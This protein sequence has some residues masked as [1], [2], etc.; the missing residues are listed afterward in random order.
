M[1]FPKPARPIDSEVAATSA[2]LAAVLTIGLMTVG[3]YGITSDEFLFDAYGPKALAWYLSGFTDRTWFDY[4]DERPYGPWFQ[5]LVTAVQSLGLA[6]R[7]TV[8]HAVTFVIGI[9]GLAALL[10]LARL[11]VGRWA[12]FSAIVL[13]LITG[14]LYGHLFFTPYD[15]P[16][17]ATMTWATLA[18][19]VMARDPV[20][21]W[22]VV[23]AVGLLT[24]LAIATRPGGVLVQIYLLAAMALCGLEA[25]LA[26]R[27][28]VVLRR[29]GMRTAVAILA[30]WPVAIALWPF[31]QVQ[32][33]A[34]GFAIAFAH[35]ANIG[36]DFGIW[37]WGQRLSSAALPWRY[38]PG[39][40]L[41]RLPT[42]F[43][44]LLAVAAVCG[45]ANAFRLAVACANDM[46]R[47]GRAGMLG[48]LA[49]LAHNRAMLVLATAAVA[50]L[51]FV[52]VMRPIIF[53]GI[54]HL[55]FTIPLLALLATWGL[56]RL[57]PLVRR[58]PYVWSTLAGAYVAAAVGTMALLHPLEYVATNA[59]AGGV[60]RSVGRFDLDYW[61]GAATEAL[62]RLEQR[63]AY[64]DSQRVASSPPRIHICI[65]WREQL[66]APMFRRPWKL[67]FD[68]QKAEYVIETERSHCA[69]R[70][71]AVLIDEVKRFDRAF[72]WTYQNRAAGG[73]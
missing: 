63:V 21:S 16:F 60:A 67:E 56:L 15:V 64:D 22:G 70:A 6:E 46:Q 28:R 32:N 14:N 8:R 17:L 36:L 50:P 66:V 35:F 7:F 30:A 42:V 65:P 23:A 2:L 73:R 29:M 58:L 31:L 48:A 51:A 62:R 13:C 25:F 19:V 61:L 59:L 26:R 18:V 43:I 38:V 27:D 57:L 41:A 34:V 1:S 55:L 44:A 68:P 47:H 37:H 24:G 52:M 3:D 54:R 71:Q 9:G 11:T 4:L 10:P 72:A 49:V 5:M 53:D 20:P 40:L 45:G 33:P 39:E 69:P 12:G